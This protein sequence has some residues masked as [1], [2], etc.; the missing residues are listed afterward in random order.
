MT[1]VVRQE[2]SQLVRKGVGVYEHLIRSDG[3]DVMRVDFRAFC[4][5]DIAYDEKLTEF[6]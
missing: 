6:Q 1:G 5:S 3:N 2:R 4:A